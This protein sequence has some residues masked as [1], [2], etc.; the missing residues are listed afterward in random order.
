MGLSEF[1]NF[2]TEFEDVEIQEGIVDEIA[3][4]KPLMVEELDEETRGQSVKHPTSTS[5]GPSYGRKKKISPCP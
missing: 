5:A 3:V 4:D 1:L 2:N